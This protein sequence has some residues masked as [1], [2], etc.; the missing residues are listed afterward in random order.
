MQRTTL[1]RRHSDALG[2]DS[3][4]FADV[5][6][7]MVLYHIRV[8]SLLAVPEHLRLD[9]QRR[10]GALDVFVPALFNRCASR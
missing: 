4:A 3:G 1:P 9:D 6:G 2:I 7:T 5:I 10:C 8:F